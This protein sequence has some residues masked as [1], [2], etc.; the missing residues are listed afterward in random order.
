[1]EEEMERLHDK[2]TASPG[3]QANKLEKDMVHKKRHE[4]GER[5][6]DEDELTKFI[7]KRGCAIMPAAL[8]FVFLK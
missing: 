8:T 6:L 3:L 7:S 4:T 1:M 2:R 5:E